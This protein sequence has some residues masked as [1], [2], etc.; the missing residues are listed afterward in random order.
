MVREHLRHGRDH[1]RGDLRPGDVPFRVDGDP[2]SIERTQALLGE[3][4]RSGLI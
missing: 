3:A 2:G 4:G 1:G